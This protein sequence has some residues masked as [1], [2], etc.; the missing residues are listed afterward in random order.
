M[1]TLVLLFAILA[2]SFAGNIL[3]S[4]SSGSVTVTVNQAGPTATL[5]STPV[6]IT[7]SCSVQQGYANGGFV[8]YQV[9]AYLSS[10][11]TSDQD[12]AVTYNYTWLDGAHNNVTDSVTIPAGSTSAYTDKSLSPE[13]TGNGSPFSASN[14]TCNPTS[15]SPSTYKLTWISTN[16]TSCTSPGFA[17]GNATSN[18]TGVPV[19]PS[20][21][22]T[23]TITCTGPGGSA[24][25]S[26]TIGPPPPP[27][28]VFVS[29]S[30]SAIITGGSSTIFWN[31]SN[32]T[33]SCTSSQISTGNAIS[34]S[35]TVSPTSDTNYVVTCTGPGGTGS[36]SALVTVSAGGNLISS[37]LGTSDQD[38]CSAK[39]KN[40]YIAP[41]YVFFSSGASVYY[42]AA[43]S[44][45]VV[46]Y[47]LITD[48]DGSVYNLQNNIIGF[49][50]GQL[51]P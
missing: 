45:P 39:Y 33:S 48:T 34:G 28:S 14:V 49:P 16:A 17:T 31:V 22:T 41:P 2:L 9:Y 5:T 50:T 46:G 35:R 8:N 18:N 21:Q 10:P 37:R 26:V 44:N 13:S 51:C 4:T 42:D 27:P 38:I 32:Q 40:Y 24:N 30:P 19:T 29:A 36:G 20:V 7:V 15:V 23:Y 25:S 3:A 6:P 12:I 11:S 43:V 47:F 1:R